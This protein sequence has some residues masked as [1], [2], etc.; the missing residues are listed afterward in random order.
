MI[1]QK[2]IPLTKFT[3]DTY[4]DDYIEDRKAANA[5]ST[6][7]EK[8]RTA[9]HFIKYCTENDITI[10]TDAKYDVL[11][12]V[13]GFFDTDRLT[14]S[15]TRL[16]HLRDFFGYISRQLPSTRDQDK[17]RDIT[18]KIE[19]EMWPKHVFESDEKEPEFISEADIRAA[20][21]A[22]STR[23]ELAIRFLFYTGCRLGEMLAVTPADVTFDREDVGAAIEITNQRTRQGELAPTKTENSDRVVEVDA[24]TAQLLREWI[25][26]NDVASDE[27]IFDKSH[28]TYYGDVK[29]AFTEV[30]VLV[31]PETGKSFVSP[32][33]LRHNRNTRIKKEHGAVA[34]QQYMGHEDSEMTDHYTHFD[35]HEVQGIV[36]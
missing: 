13:R 12:T 32:H 9:R 21:Q 25:E 28:S 33:W 1:L 5:E 4:L 3:P 35:P 27:Y 8:A 19:K 7:T 17:L 30:D 20:W 23:A 15:S 22:G 36:G 10:N 6:A 11:D 18:D 29:G 16:S 2:V 14:V 26:S 24:E 31:N 34:A